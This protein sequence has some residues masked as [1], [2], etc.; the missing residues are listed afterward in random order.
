MWQFRGHVASDRVVGMIL[1]LVE[2]CVQLSLNAFGMKVDLLKLE[3]KVFLKLLVVKN[4]KQA[5]KM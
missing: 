1:S 2:Y 4:S 3:D 5:F